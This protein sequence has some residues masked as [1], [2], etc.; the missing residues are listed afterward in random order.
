M[1]QDILSFFASNGVDVRPPG[2]I[3]SCATHSVIDRSWAEFGTVIQTIQHTAGCTLIRTNT[4]PR[5]WWGHEQP[6]LFPEQ[7]ALHATISRHDGFGCAMAFL[8][9]PL[10]V[11]LE[12]HLRLPQNFVAVH[13]RTG[14][15][16][17]EGSLEAVDAAQVN[18]SLHCAR[19]LAERLFGGA[20]FH[21]FFAS[22]SS[23][24]KALAKQQSVPLGHTVFTTEASAAHI[25]HHKGVVDRHHFLEG[26]WNDFVILQ[27]LGFA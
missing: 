2:G 19:Q 25:D 27:Q 22:G 13:M 10:E 21:I 14:D 18:S 15:G 17:M 6:V 3:Q 1:G 11:L 4:D 9:K 5:L 26:V 24:A 8:F 16:D 12:Q 20:A 23:A 7:Q